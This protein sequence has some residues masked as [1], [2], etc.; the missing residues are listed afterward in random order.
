MG[1]YISQKAD[2]P[3]LEDFLCGALGGAIGSFNLLGWL[4]IFFGWLNPTV[5]LS[6][7]AGM[8]LLLGA[9]LAVSNAKE[10]THRAHYR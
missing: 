8:G 1:A 3:W 9:W 5:T 4:F 7:C 2:S 10:K 6:L